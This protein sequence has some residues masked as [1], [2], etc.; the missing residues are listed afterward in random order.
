MVQEDCKGMKLT[1]IMKALCAVALIVQ[2]LYSAGVAKA[3]EDYPVPQGN[4]ATWGIPGHTERLPE[5]AQA[6]PPSIFS[7]P[8][9]WGNEAQNG[10]S[11]PAGE[12]EE[13]Y[14]GTWAFNGMAGTGIDRNG[15]PESR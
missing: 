14:T 10:V 8:R 11:G 4:P 13:K 2:I 6:S 3:Q 9:S 15:I 12:A 1:F 7:A 5:E